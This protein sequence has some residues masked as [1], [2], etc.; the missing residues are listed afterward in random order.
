MAGAAAI[1][2]STILE[3]CMIPYLKRTKEAAASGP[4]ESIKRESDDGEDYDVLES[5]AEDLINAVHAK[6]VKA[7]AAAIRAAFDLCDSMPHEEGPHIN[8]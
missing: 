1:L 6:D 5:A 7:A 4:V 3:S 8:Q 2:L